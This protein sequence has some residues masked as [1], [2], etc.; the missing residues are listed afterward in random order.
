MPC[1]I[2]CAADL[3]GTKVNYELPFP[4]PPSHAELQAKIEHI[5]VPEHGVRRPAS[6]PTSQGFVVERM[7]TFDE[8]AQQWV[9]L[10]TPAQLSDYSQIYLFQKENEHHREVQSKIPPPVPTPAA[11][12]AAAAAATAATSPSTVAAEQNDSA[13]ASRAVVAPPAA[14]APVPATVPAAAAVPAPAPVGLEQLPA[15]QHG[16]TIPTFEKQRGV[17]DEL[18][19]KKARTVDQEAFLVCLFPP[20]V[21]LLY[22]F[23]SCGHTHTHTVSSQSRLPS[24]ASVLTK[25][26][27]TLRRSSRRRTRTRTGLCRT[28]SGSAFRTSTRLFSTLCTS[29]RR[30]WERLFAL[31]VFVDGDDVI[32]FSTRRCAIFFAVFLCYFPPY[33]PLAQDFWADSQQ[34]QE[35]EKNKVAL[36]GYALFLIKILCFTYPTRLLLVLLSLRAQHKNPLALLPGFVTARRRCA[37]RRCRH[38]LR[39]ARR[40]RSCR[41]RRR[42]R[43]T[44]R[45]ARGRRS[46]CSRRATTTRRGAGAS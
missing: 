11:A 8:R 2:L 19:A 41:R 15:S 33:L 42:R 21:V 26:R 9:D 20:C 38:R 7:Q 12:A 14:S 23:F 25:A 45:H 18:D 16:R 37:C 13:A 46:L 44:P 3:W 28:R 1:T 22:V 39:P 24:S 30:Y 36:D 4:H 6:V 35:I 31:L 17:Y 5:F 40:S 34:Q 32:R 29:G 27:R 10:L 43:R